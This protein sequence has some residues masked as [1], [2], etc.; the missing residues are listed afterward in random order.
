MSEVVERTEQ[1]YDSRDADEFYFRIWGGEDIHVGLYQNGEQDIFAAS[2]RTVETMAAKVAHLPAS[3]RVLDIGAGYGGAA[4]YLARERG[5]CVTCLN[6]SKVQN[7]RNRE[8]N[9]QQ[10]LADRIEVVD[11]NFEAL[12]FTDESFDA[13]WSQD[14]ILHSGNRFKVFQEA[15]RVL[16]PGG[17]MIF[18]DPMQQP[19]ADP[20]ALRP[21]LDRIH[22]ETMGSIEDYSQYANQLGWQ[23]KETDECTPQLVNHYT[24]VLANLEGRGDEL[25]NIVSEQYIENMKKGLRHW[26]Q[27]GKSG[28]L[29]WGILVFQK[30]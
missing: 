8:M 7:E 10:G 18:T 1:Y 3:V 21:V 20:V 26:I 4:R 11:G 25:T 29:C 9:L 15:D 17:T 16:K 5:Y 23:V 2:R 30:G 6:L 13:I 24:A 19:N 12:P 14:A 22:L 28:L 27:A